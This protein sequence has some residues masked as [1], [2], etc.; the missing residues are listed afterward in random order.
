MQK[1]TQYRWVLNSILLALAAAGFLVAGAALGGL[2]GFLL[3]LAILLLVVVLAAW[4]AASYAVARPKDHPLH[5]GGSARQQA[6]RSVAE[7]ARREHEQACVARLAPYGPE[8]WHLQSRDGLR[9]Q[10]VF[11]PGEPGE[12]RAAIL[13]HGHRQTNAQ[14]AEYALY[15]RGKLGLNVLMPNARAHGASEGKT[16]GMGWPDRLDCIDWMD[17][18]IRRLGPDCRL[19]LYGISMGGATVMM[20]LN[21][22]LPPQL[23]FVAEDCGYTSVYDELVHQLKHSFNLPPFPLVQV[24]GLIIRLWAGYDPKRASA[25]RGVAG[26]TLP[27]LFVHGDADTYVPYA[28]AAPLF[29]ASASIDKELVTVAGAGHVRAFPDDKDGLV[30]AA[31]E[32][33]IGRYMQA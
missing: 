11:L 33:Y 13:L 17:T 25:L 4:Y 10:A 24:G 9:L 21:E 3:V 27:I 22:P 12:Q 28:M 18:L 23:R 30:K 2:A 7:Q 20:A 29:A 32:R 8:E 6:R 16:I 5:G 31:L 15:F 26:N 14:M 19:M 1:L